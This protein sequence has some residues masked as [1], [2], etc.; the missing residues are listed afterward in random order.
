MEGIDPVEWHSGTVGGGDLP[1]ENVR[2]PEMLRCAPAAGHSEG[3]GRES[4]PDARRRAAAAPAP[5]VFPSI[6]FLIFF[7]RR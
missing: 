4:L 5:L 6:P 1:P 7:C 2:F 3:R